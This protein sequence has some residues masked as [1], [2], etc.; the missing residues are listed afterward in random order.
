MGLWLARYGDFDEVV[1]T[2]KQSL[3]TPTECNI[4]A[5]MSKLNQD[6]TTQGSVVPNL[7]VSSHAS[8]TFMGLDWDSHVDLDALFQTHFETKPLRVVLAADVLYGQEVANVFF[9]VLRRLLQKYSVVYPDRTAP[10]IIVAQKLRADAPF[11][12]AS[13]SEFEATLLLEEYYVRVWRL[14]IR[15]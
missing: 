10:H 2:D 15:V 12:V 14:Q 11:D 3:K 1:L 9:G 8:V 4:A 5:N 13:I 7:I 6:I